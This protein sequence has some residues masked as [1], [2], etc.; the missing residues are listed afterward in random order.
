[1]EKKRILVACGTSIAT[2][3]LAGVKVKEIAD[4]AGIPVE[5]IQCKAI[6]IRGR[7]QTVHPHLIVAMTPVPDD[8][9]VPVVMGIPFI[10][11]V[12]IPQVKEQ[13]LNHLRSTG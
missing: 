13:I 1:M 4:E 12:G 2:A 6:E 5:I 8:L 9:G 11:G 3:T 7:V 10:S